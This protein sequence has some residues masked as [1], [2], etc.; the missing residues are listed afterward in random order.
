MP[1]KRKATS[2]ASAAPAVRQPTKKAAPPPAAA[3]AAAQP[4]PAKRQRSQAGRGGRGRSDAAQPTSWLELDDCEQFQTE[5]AAITDSAALH[6][7][8]QHLRETDPQKHRLIEANPMAFAAMLPTLRPEDDNDEDDGE[9]GSGGGG[10]DGG[11]DGSG[12]GSDE[13]SDDG[14]APAHQPDSPAGWRQT[15]VPAH[16]KLKWSPQHGAWAWVGCR[17]GFIRLAAHAEIPSSRRTAAAKAA[18]TRSS[19][20]GGLPC[21]TQAALSAP[22]LRLLL[23]WGCSLCSDACTEVAGDAENTWGGLWKLG[24]ACVCSLST[25]PTI[26]LTGDA[27]VSPVRRL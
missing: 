20:R 15:A 1:P 4:P 7:F 3:E 19:S 26:Y 13:R 6:V 8:L 23:A 22:G 16:A 24:M 21:A 9:S 11:S 12:G 25:E 14:A 27:P 10:S 2:A 5:V 18:H 17:G